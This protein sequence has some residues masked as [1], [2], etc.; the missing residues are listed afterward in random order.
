MSVTQLTLDGGEVPYPIP[1]SRPL[2][3]AQREIL[4]WVRAKG[5]IRSSEAGVAVHAV[6]DGYYCGRLSPPSAL[7]CCEFASSAGSAACKRLSARGLLRRE[8]FGLWVLP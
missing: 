8:R 2:S 7:G 3:P 6:H 4:K 1:R 5:S